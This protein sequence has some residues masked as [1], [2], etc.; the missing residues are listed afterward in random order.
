MSC[1]I[2]YAKRTVEER[3]LSFRAHD[4]AQDVDGDGE[5]DL[6]S[7]L[8]DGGALP[9]AH[10]LDYLFGMLSTAAGAAANMERE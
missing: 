8:A 5:A 7:V 10:K 1:S 2:Y 9:S 3:L 4:L 6:I